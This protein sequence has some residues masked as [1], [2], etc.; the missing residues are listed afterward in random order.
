LRTPA[1]IPPGSLLIYDLDLIRINAIGEFG[2]TGVNPSA[3]KAANPRPS[4]SAA[5][6]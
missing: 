3:G 6:P 1:S 2:P 4:A 5:K